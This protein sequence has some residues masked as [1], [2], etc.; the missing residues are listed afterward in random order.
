MCQYRKFFTFTVIG[1]IFGHVT[2]SGK[3]I[4]YYREFG[5]CHCLGLEVHTTTQSSFAITKAIDNLFILWFEGEG[6]IWK[7]DM[8]RWRWICSTG[9]VYG[10]HEMRIYAVTWEATMCCTRQLLAVDANFCRMEQI[11]AKKGGCYERR[12]CAVGA[13]ICHKG[14]LWMPIG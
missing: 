12:L 4:C 6:V 1:S 3:H 13:D 14:C 5:F 7:V 8:C 2:L 11:F 10:C 9:D